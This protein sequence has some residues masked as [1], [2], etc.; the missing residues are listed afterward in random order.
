MNTVL[1]TSITLD[2]KKNRIRIHKSL[3]SVLGEPHYV[4]LLVNP[5][6]RKI[7]IRAVDSASAFAQPIK[8]SKQKSTEKCYEFYSSILLDKLYEEMKLSD[9]NG[10]YRIE[11]IV[12]PEEKTA[13]FSFDSIEKIVT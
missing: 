11:G 3:Y 8:I 13:L 6:V 2:M 1:K 10:S 12:L 5:K 7:G 9:K 4:Q